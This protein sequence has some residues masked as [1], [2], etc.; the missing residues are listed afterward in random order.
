M[1]V[2]VN[3]AFRLRDVYAF[4]SKDPIYIYDKTWSTVFYSGIDLF[5]KLATEEHTG[6]EIITFTMK[7]LRNLYYSNRD[8]LDQD[9]TIDLQI[10]IA[11]PIDEITRFD[12]FHISVCDFID[13]IRSN[14]SIEIQLSP[15]NLLIELQYEPYD[16]WSDEYQQIITPE[17]FIAV[18]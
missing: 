16:F 11:S 15:T 13:L 8:Q 7:G 18:C 17:N 10:A 14:E 3:Y 4:I 2:L 9:T 5:T 1:S 12:V 6:D